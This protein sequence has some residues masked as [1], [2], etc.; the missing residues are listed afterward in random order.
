M[1]WHT[2]FSCLINRDRGFLGSLLPTSGTSRSGPKLSLTTQKPRQILFGQNS[3]QSAPNTPRRRILCDR[4]A[5]RRHLLRGQRT[6]SIALR[7]RSL[8]RQNS[9][10]QLRPPTIAKSST[11]HSSSL[12]IARTRISAHFQ[13]TA[14]RVLRMPYEPIREHR[15]KR[16][17]PYFPVPCLP[18][19]TAY[20]YRL[21]AKETI[22]TTLEG[23]R[24]SPEQRSCLAKTEA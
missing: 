3:C 18:K 6:Q 4:T 12:Q 13:C 8:R 14:L 7:R 2:R 15:R 5:A 23:S 24:A 21:P 11:L 9:C 10:C 16:S 22:S 20:C 1:A 17:A 19:K